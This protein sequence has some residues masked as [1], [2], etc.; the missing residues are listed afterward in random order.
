MIVKTVIEYEKKDYDDFRE[1]LTDEQAADILEY[2]KRGYI[3]DY[4]YSGSED[5][6][7]RFKMHMAM[8]RAIDKLRKEIK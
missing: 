3:P 4:N 1:S 6:F 2:V 8:Y 5:D 7:E